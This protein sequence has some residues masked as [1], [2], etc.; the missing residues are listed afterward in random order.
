MINFKLTS[1]G[2]HYNHRWVFKDLNFE[3]N[4]PIIG[5]SGTNGT[6]KST[7][8]KI[9]SGLIQ[10]D[11]GTVEWLNY[12]DPGPINMRLISGYAA[13]YIQLYGDLTCRENLDFLRSASTKE[14]NSDEID[15][16]AKEF[17]IPE[18]LDR[19]YKSLSSGQQQRIKILSAIQSSPAILFLDEPGTNL[20]ENGIGFIQKIIEKRRY[21]EEICIIASNLSHELALCDQIISLTGRD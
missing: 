21:N 12:P 9:L 20:D 19:P 7:L 14:N 3:S 10:S 13:P 1:L 17:G 18:K 8:L 6:G 5:I 11:T 16:L 4:A 2:K 15:V